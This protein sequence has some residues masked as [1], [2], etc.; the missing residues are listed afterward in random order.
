MK[1]IEDV[2]CIK[3]EDKSKN[4]HTE[5]VSWILPNTVQMRTLIFSSENITREKDY[6][7]FR[8]GISCYS[9]AGRVGK[10]Q[11]IVFFERCAEEHTLIHEVKLLGS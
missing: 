10:R 1:K 4:N 2:T 3:F 9:F 8:D 5:R 7:E 6:I 11:E